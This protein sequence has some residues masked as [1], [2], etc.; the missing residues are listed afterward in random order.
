MIRWKTKPKLS[1]DFLLNLLLICLVLTLSSCQSFSPK[2][3]N[4][5]SNQSNLEEVTPQLKALDLE[6]ENWQTIQ[7]EGVSLS[8][9]ESYRGGNPLR[10]LTEIEDAL[11]GLDKS[12]GRRLQ[13]IKQNL[14]Q[15]VFLAFDARATTPDA[16]SNVS[17]LKQS[18]EPEITLETYL[19]KA[20]KTLEKTHKIEG[21][22]IT[23][24]GE[25]SLGRIIATVTTEE[26][27]AMKQL[28]YFQPETEVIWITNYTTPK[29]EFQNR[30]SNFEQSIASLEIN[31]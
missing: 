5:S 1:R 6:A 11:S 2:D 19:E 29:S 15:I 20:V 30:V 14:D 12:Y 8:L 7:G 25:K 13:G 26:G 3:P 22:I 17:I 23:T 24:Q 4:V 18:I 10:D 31:S 28:F 21:E 16:L 9:P 27:V